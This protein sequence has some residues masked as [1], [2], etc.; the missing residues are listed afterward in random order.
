MLRVIEPNSRPVIDVA[1]GV[2]MRASGEVL[3]AQRPA[4]KL[5]AG[6]WEFPGGKLECGETPYQ[7]LRRELDEELGV[8]IRGGKRLAR[9][10]QDYSDRRVWLDTWLIDDFHGEPQ[11]RENQ[12][13]EWIAPS[14]I[15]DFDVLPSCWR[16]AAALQMPREYV[17][18]PPQST[19]ASLLRGLA[20]LPSG[21]LLRLRLPALDD[22]AYQAIAIALT[23]P[24]R[25]RAIGLV[26]D[27]A[28]SQVPALGAVGWHASSAALAQL[29]SRPLPQGIW[30]LA[31]AHDAAQ[32][33]RAHAIGADAVIVGPVLDTA[34]HP[35]ATTLG[36]PNFAALAEQA[37]L[38]A[39]A[40]GGLDASALEHVQALGGFGI[41]A[42][43][44]YWPTRG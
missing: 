6:K 38:P 29:D 11:P 2:L 7:A 36:W 9:L 8:Q 37:G 23:E 33:A 35:G 19:L 3:L 31:S 30:V 21:A 32:I 42:I 34:S 16:V 5:A 40:I 12:Q 27:R 44:A 15:G 1:C 14:R 4:G 43:S 24:A 20:H 10:R 25:A 22:A 26:L 28:P 13:F 17:I 18:T 39:Y 41:A